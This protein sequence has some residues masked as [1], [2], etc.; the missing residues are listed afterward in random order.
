MK[1]LN[2]PILLALTL[3]WL[4]SCQS[5]QESPKQVYQPQSDARL[6]TDSTA[7]QPVP[8]ATAQEAPAT[9][10]GA[11][12]DQTKLPARQFIRTADIKFRVDN[13]VNAT[14]RIEAITARYGGFVTFTR[15]D[16]QKDDTETVAISADS[17]LETTRFT[18]SNSMT[19]RVPNA[20]LDTTLCALVGLS[21]YLDFREIK[22]DDVALQRLAAAQ[23]QQRNTA[24]TQRLR[25]AIDKRGSTLGDVNDTEENR[26]THQQQT[27]EARINDLLLVDQLQLSTITLTIYQRQSCQRTVLPNGN[28]V[29]AYEPAFL[30][31]A[32]DALATGG[33]VLANV[34]LLLLEGWGIILFCLVAYVLIRYIIGRF[35]RTLLART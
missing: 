33:H 6:L 9:L 23:T 7:P 12:A 3:L 4:A 2:N 1:T 18:V 13:V 30:T 16:S 31:K 28:D 15:L 11:S 20:R 22:S 24:Y 5:K 34:I 8:E 14:N 29:K 10:P 27:D 25:A 35:R 17:L 19:L 32:A 26:L 21:D